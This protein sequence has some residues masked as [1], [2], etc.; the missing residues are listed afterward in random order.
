MSTFE[1]LESYK[2]A[3]SNLNLLLNDKDKLKNNILFDWFKYY[4]L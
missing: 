4:T 2:S 3:K 1:Q